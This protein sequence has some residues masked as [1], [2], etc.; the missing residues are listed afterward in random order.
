MPGDALFHGQMAQVRVCSVARPEQ[1]FRQSP[2]TTL[3]RPEPG[4]V[5]LWNFDDPANPGRDSS[6]NGHHANLM[7]NALVGP[8]ITSKPGRR[9]PAEYVLEL[10]GDSGYVELAAGIVA[11]LTEAT[12]EGAVPW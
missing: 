12:E 9:T 10:G 3:S 4:L 2:Y 11:G 5:G 7:G 1:Q 8:S 6:P